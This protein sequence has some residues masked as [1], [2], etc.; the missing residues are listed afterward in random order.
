MTRNDLL[1]KVLFAALPLLFVFAACH[2]EKKEAKME[3][4]TP[5]A[6][7]DGLLLCITGEG[8]GK[9][10][11][12][13]GLAARALGH[14][15]KVVIVQFLKKGKSGEPRLPSRAVWLVRTSRTGMSTSARS[16]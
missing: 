9:T 4:G 2:S 12:A 5:E 14:E 11:A 13:M 10:T 15:K 3:T 1:K 6:E 16:Q 7:R 8:K